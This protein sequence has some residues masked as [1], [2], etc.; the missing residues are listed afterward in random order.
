MA[1]WLP[2]CLDS[3]L[4]QSVPEIEIICV[5]DCSS[6]R[7]PEILE[8]YRLSRPDRF[9][10]IRHS[11]R[12]G[13]GAARNAGIRLARGEY[14]MFM[15]ADETYPDGALEALYGAA[16]RENADLARGNLVYV[17]A[18]PGNPKNDRHPGW[19]M[20]IV[21]ESVGD[22]TAHPSG[23]LP[24]SHYCYLIRKSLILDN[25]VA[26]PDY[27]RGQDPVFLA[28]LLVK[29][30]KIVFV[31]FTVYRYRIHHKADT[32]LKGGLFTGY[33]QSMY[34]V[35]KIFAR[36][37]KMRYGIFFIL[38]NINDITKR[39][40]WTLCS[41]LRNQRTVARMSSTLGNPAIDRDFSP[42]N[43]HIPSALRRLRRTAC[44]GYFYIVLSHI[45][46]RLFS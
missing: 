20:E 34:D 5:D 46:R 12:R 45:C 36:H 6:D 21:A 2:E 33:L 38:F 18:E 24:W 30:E 3:I 17:S 16:Q 15:D 35:L 4:R 28:Q 29:A 27:L 32:L 25:A 1:P 10:L 41:S 22:M 19:S 9:V 11:E 26:Y 14:C 31:P 13:S 23:W 42:Y 37:D 44:F 7:S 43:V 8:K 40:S 39:Q